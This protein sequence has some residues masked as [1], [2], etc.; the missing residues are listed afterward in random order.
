MRWRR[1]SA[2]I[3]SARSSS[4]ARHAA[5][6]KSHSPGVDGGGRV[7]ER[8]FAMPVAALTPLREPAFRRL[9]A[10]RVSSAV[11]D[12]VMAGALAFAVL[13]ATGSIAGVGLV[14]AATRVPLVLFVLV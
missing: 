9:W 2:A 3:S 11:G 8:V 5:C 13:D 7:G 6:G 10:A 12:A 1:S 4:P 14:L